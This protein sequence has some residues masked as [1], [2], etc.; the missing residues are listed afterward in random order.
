[1]KQLALFITTLSLMIAGDCFPQ[2][3]S[4]RIAFAT[5]IDHEPKLDG[6]LE[7][8]VWLTAKPITDFR[9]R[10]PN[11]GEAAT[12]RT[13]V[14]ILY[15]RREIFFGITCFESEAGHVM[16]TELRR[17]VSQGFD[18]HFEIVI[19]SAHDRR[20]AY[21]FQINALGTQRDGLIIEENGGGEDYD[22]AWDGIWVS[23][24]QRTQFGWTATVAIP[25]STLNITSSSDL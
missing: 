16:A 8:P 23:A 9:Q 22:A 25:F 6:G 2:S 18:D 1:M 7:D 5:R 10:E 14:R 12:E 17:D 11:E 13:E 24:A 4:P 19:D 15:T 21:A 3:G 20:N